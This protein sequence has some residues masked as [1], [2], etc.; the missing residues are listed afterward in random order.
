MATIHDVAQ[1]AG[2]SPTTVSR[3]LNNRIALPATTSARI[4]AAIRKLDYRPN[5]LA[6]RLSTGRTEA[7]GLAMPTIRD[8]FHAA[9]AAAVEEEADRRGYT[10][11]INATRG[12]RDREIAAINRL[13]DRHADG[14]IMLIDGPD[15]GTLTR[16][17]G[18]QRDVLLVREEMA[19]EA[20]LR[21]IDAW[22]LLGRRAVRAL[23]ASLDARRPQKRTVLLIDVAAGGRPAQPA[24]RGQFQPVS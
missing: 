21:S 17:I 6:R 9:L 19:G 3:Y 18:R 24:G 5:V 16:L 4:D 2:V 7:I 8:P 14:L 22:D 13:H 12:D 1:Q 15:D 11:F 10:V 20:L 23:F